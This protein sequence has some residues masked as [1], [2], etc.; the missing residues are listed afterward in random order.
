[1]RRR[2]NSA[3]NQIDVMV[4]RVRNTLIVVLC[5]LT[6]AMVPRQNCVTETMIKRLVK[7]MKTCKRKSYLSVIVKTFHCKTLS[8]RIAQT[9]VQFKTLHFPNF[10]QAQYKEIVI[11]F[12][13]ECSKRLFEKACT[14]CSS[15][16]FNS[17]TLPIA[18]FQVGVLV[19]RSCRC[20]FVVFGLFRKRT[21][22]T[23]CLVIDWT[24]LFHSKCK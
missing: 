11:T 9:Y 15:T 20:T 7:P 10:K 21:W 2:R 12:V 8:L 13:K 6:V 16:E 17:L 24:T 14:S 5:S 4:S 18:I 23:W 1:M 3:V 19:L 22:F